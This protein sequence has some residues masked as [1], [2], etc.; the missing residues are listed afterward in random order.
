MYNTFSNDASLTVVMSL[1]GQTSS[2]SSSLYSYV[3]LRRKFGTQCR[4]LNGRTAVIYFLRPSADWPGSRSRRRQRRRRS[5]FSVPAVFD[6]FEPPPPPLLAVAPTRNARDPPSPPPRP[7]PAGRRAKTTYC[8]LTGRRGKNLF[9]R[10]KPSF[11]E[12]VK[13]AALLFGRGPFP[14][15]TG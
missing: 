9:A 5:G 14:N 7:P 13:A 6:T 3:W 8:G 10:A 1:V 15:R 12:T 2:S 11:P 4:R